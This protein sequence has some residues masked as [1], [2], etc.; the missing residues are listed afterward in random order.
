MRFFLLERPLLSSQLSEE[1]NPFLGL[2]TVLTD[3]LRQVLVQSA[4]QACVATLLT[5]NHLYELSS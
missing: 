5:L 1:N 3:Q 4:D 2:Q